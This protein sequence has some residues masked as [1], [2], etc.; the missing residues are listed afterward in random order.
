MPVDYDSLASKLG[1]VK[2]EPTIDYAALAAKNGAVDSSSAKQDGMFDNL[3]YK[4]IP[5][6]LGNLA[7]GAVRGAAGIGGTIAQPFQYLA[8]GALGNNAEM[9]ANLDKNIANTF[10][11]DTESGLYKTGKIGAEIGITAPL[12]GAVGNVVGKIAPK[13]G[14]SIASGGFNLGSPA[15]TTTGEML[16]NAATRVSGGAINGGITAGMVNPDDSGTGALIGGAFPIAGKIAGETGKL[17][18]T[19]ADYG[20]SKLDDAAH[21]LMTSAL[22]PTIAQHRSGDAAKAVQTLL[23]EGINP[24]NGGVEKLKN[25]VDNIDY[26]IKDKIS[27]S[28]ATIDKQKVID[29]LRTTKQDFTNQVDP[30]ADLN[31]IQ[32]VGD[33]FNMHPAISGNDIPVQQA[34][35]FKTGTYGILKKKYGQVGTADTEAQK[36]L[37]RGLK[38]QIANA[39]PDIA[40]LNARQSNLL[41]SLDVTERRAF[42]DG[43]KNPLGLTSLTPSMKNA[44]LFMADKSALIK[45]LLARG[46]YQ[47]SQLK[48]TTVN[49]NLIELLKDPKL[50]NSMEVLSAQ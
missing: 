1:A 6:N 11:A 25:L 33:R 38:E 23:D 12:G 13:L 31:T 19:A 49:K 4:N 17:L 47:T 34:Q 37:A 14:S 36:A 39:V 43:N 40:D 42:M 27:N 44:A 50:I 18:N 2:S 24:T 16:G 15:A 28:T 30:I 8:G 21:Y 32:D 26:Q 9:K 22:K 5:Q 48:S 35:D 45:S 46:S 41:G 7:A 20:K 3:S 29:A 10:G